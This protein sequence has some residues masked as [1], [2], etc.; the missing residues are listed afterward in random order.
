MFPFFLRKPE[1]EDEREEKLRAILTSR[2]GDLKKTKPGVEYPHTC[3]ECGWSAFM[4]ARPYCTNP[5]CKWYDRK[6]LQK[7]PDPEPAD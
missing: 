6:R 1:E 2:H 3:T 5:G 7:Q 4:G